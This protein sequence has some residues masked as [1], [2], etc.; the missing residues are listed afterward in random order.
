MLILA[1]FLVSSVLGVHLFISRQSSPGKL[2]GLYTL[3]IG[4][5]AAEPLLIR[6]APARFAM[7]TVVAVASFLL[8]P[9][10]YLYT[11]HR[12]RESRWKIRDLVHGSPALLLLLF[13]I[14]APAP[15][16][17][18]A[19]AVAPPDEVILYAL[20]VIQLLGYTLAACVIASR[21]RFRRPMQI[22]REMQ[23]AFVMPL[24]TASLI[25]FVYSVITSLIPMNRHTV[26]ASIQLLLGGVIIVITLLNAENLEKHLKE[27]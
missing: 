10:L 4:I 24:I 2:L 26:T 22:R 13:M 20:F 16:G 5:A 17:E 3:A 23:R 7:E 14:L 1:E 25:L 27:H 18:T 9:L 19:S 11:C 6:V 21:Y 15:D 12:I 8:G